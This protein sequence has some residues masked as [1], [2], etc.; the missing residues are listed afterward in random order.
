MIAYLIKHLELLENMAAAYPDLL[1]PEARAKL[2]SIH[3]FFGG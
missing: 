1:T 3:D 2:V